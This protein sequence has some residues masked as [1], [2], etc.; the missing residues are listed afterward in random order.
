MGPYATKD[1]ILALGIKL[2]PD[3]V[4]A[5]ISDMF[6]NSATQII[7]VKTGKT[8]DTIAATSLYIDGR[9]EPFIF[10]PITPILTLTGLK[11]IAGDTTEESLDVAGTDR[12]VW[13]NDQ[14]GLISRINSQEDI[15]RPYSGACFPHGVKNIKI[16]GTFGKVSTELPILELLQTLLVFQMLGLIFPSQFRLSD[17]TG[18]KIGEYSYTLAAMEY[19]VNPNNQRKTLDGYINWLFEQLDQERDGR[20]LAI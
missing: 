18:E 6:L 16:E 4:L 10:C 14:T 20:Y 12:E 3:M 7:E 5:D 1:A 13:Y 9:G 11:I 2:K 17:L 15:A 19:S 8:W